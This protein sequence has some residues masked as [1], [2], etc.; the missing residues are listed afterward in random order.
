MSLKNVLAS[1]EKTGVKMPISGGDA[2]PDFPMVFVCNDQTGSYEVTEL[3]YLFIDHC[4]VLNNNVLDEVKGNRLYPPDE[5]GRIFDHIFVTVKKRGDE[6]EDIENL[7]FVF[8]ITEPLQAQD[9]L[10]YSFLDD[11]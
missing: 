1:I 4:M 9:P 3:M 11:L 8:D 6:D 2:S 7:V 5:N 10:D